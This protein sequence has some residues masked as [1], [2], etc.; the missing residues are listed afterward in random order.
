MDSLR[1]IHSIL[2][3][4][5]W[6]IVGQTQGIYRDIGAEVTKVFGTQAAVIRITATAEQRESPP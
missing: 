5:D 2:S 6:V 1:T 3:L 4:R